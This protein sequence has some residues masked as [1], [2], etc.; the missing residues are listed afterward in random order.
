MGL[1]AVARAF[2]HQ[3]ALQHGLD[4]LRPA[5]NPL[6]PRSAPSV[7]GDDCEVAGTR[8]VAAFLVQEDRRTGGEVRLADDELPAAPRD[9]DDGRRQTRRKRRIV[10]PE[11]AAPSRS[12]MPTTIAALSPNAIAWTSSPSSMWPRICGSAISLPRRS[13]KTA[14]SEPMKPTISPSSMNG[15]R[16]NQLVAPTSFIT[17]ISRRREKIERRIVFAIRSADEMSRRIVAIANA[18][19]RTRATFRTRSDSSSP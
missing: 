2:L 9:L 11:P 4:R 15:P 12:P 3:Q 1:E 16:T 18:V 13:R 5:E 8:F 6:E 14:N 7:R 19:D 17:S 10:R